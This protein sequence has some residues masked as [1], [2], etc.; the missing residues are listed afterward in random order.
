MFRKLM[1][2]ICL[3]TFIP[4]A[5][6]AQE[7][8]RLA[9]QQPVEQ[10]AAVTPVK[11][12]TVPS[13][14]MAAAQVMAANDCTDPA[15]GATEVK[16]PRRSHSGMTF[17]DFVDIHFGEYRWI[18]WVGAAGALVALHAFAFNKD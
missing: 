14:Q 9:S 18:Y 1:V 11:A 16:E 17:R 13:P 5:A 8:G 15:T 7:L 4:A 10:T 12:S 2:V 3:V 6:G